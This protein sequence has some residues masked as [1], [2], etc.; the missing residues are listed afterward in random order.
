V[1]SICVGPLAYCTEH[2]D[3]GGGAIAHYMLAGRH[4]FPLT[5][6]PSASLFNAMNKTPMYAFR[7]DVE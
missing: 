7:N 3:T 5:E 1:T 2:S 6:I 4:V